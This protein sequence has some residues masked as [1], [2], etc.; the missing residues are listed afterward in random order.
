MSIRRHLTYANVTATVALA[1]ALGT[2]AVYAAG[3]IGSRDIANNSIRTQDLKD[4][5]GVTGDDVKR[6]SLGGKQIDEASLVGSR[7]V[8]LQGS[9]AGDCD[10]QAGVFG[11]CASE[12]IDLKSSSQLLVIVTGGFSSEANGA[13][14][15]CEVRVDGHDEALSD[16]PGEIVDNTA[17][18][19][20]D[21][22]ARTLV[23]GSIPAGM[24]SVALACQQ[25][26]PE[27]ARIRTPTIAVLAVT[28]P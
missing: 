13:N 19:S 12:S 3:E 15:E 28:T 10:P 21:G 25:I 8:R 14:A 24:H 17:A 16:T 11:D 4:R 23:T 27:D 9:Q 6:N 22:F 20:T 5:R 18:G 2:G 26:G 7:I 1:L